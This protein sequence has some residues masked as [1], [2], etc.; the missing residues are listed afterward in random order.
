M[1]PQHFR[2]SVK[3]M[4]NMETLLAEELRAAGATKIEIAKRIVHCEGD[5]ATL[6]RIN[7]T[8]RTALRVLVPIAEF[9]IRD[10]E[11]IYE[12]GMKIDWSNFMN[13]DQTFAIDPNVHSA[14][15]KHEHYASLKLKDA[16]A[17]FFKHATGKRP[18]VD[19]ENP[20]VQI[21]L[22]VDEHRV[23]VS[24][25]SSGES[26]NRRGY[27]LAGAKAPLNEVLAAGMLLLTGWQG[28]CDFYDPM[29]GSG[30]LS[31]E[32]VMIARNLPVQMLRK[33]FGFFHWKNFDSAI[34]EGVKKEAFDQ[35]RP[36]KVRVLASD[37]DRKQ[38]EV[39]VINMKQSEE[40]EPIEVGC[41]DFFQG[42][43]QSESGLLV[44]NPPYGERI[45]DA[46]IELLYRSIGDR[47]KH[48]WPGHSAWII[49][50]NEN[51]I[52]QIGLKPSK[53]YELVNGNLVCKYL[54]IDLFSGKRKEFLE[55]RN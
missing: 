11:D 48:Y 8:C 1:L 55:G 18:D 37:I 52:K 10:V 5:L 3:T 21:S 33:D 12:R 53:K 14:F 32:A 20:D 38:L 16:V 25:D 49:S 47:L 34:W 23:T 54:R 29:C 19:P 44:M 31:M 51:A 28:E 43:P 24:L 39:A 7:F 13:I 4:Q 46:D 6:Y 26:L 45:L 50:S 9:P 15:I 40:F 2:I 22:H 27:R 41:F 42:E 17:D 36:L 30:T 35:A